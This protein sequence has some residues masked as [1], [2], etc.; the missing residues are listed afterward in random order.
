MIAKLLLLLRCDA[1]GF[2]EHIT[3]SDKNYQK[4]LVSSI[5]KTG[6]R[7]YGEKEKM[8]A[9]WADIPERAF[10]Q[11]VVWPRIVLE[12]R[13]KPGLRVL[14]IGARTYSWLPL[15]YFRK[16]NVSYW[17]LEP[18][19]PPY[20]FKP[21][22]SR[23]ENT[24]QRSRLGLAGSSHKDDD[25]SPMSLR[26]EHL[27]QATTEDF[28]E[29]DGIGGDRE[30]TLSKF[31]HFFDIVIDA[32]VL[33]G[34][35]LLRQPNITLHLRGV[36]KLMK[37]A[38]V[39]DMDPSLGQTEMPER[40]DTRLEWDSV[41]PDVNRSLGNSMNRGLRNA[42]DL[43]DKMVRLGGNFDQH[44]KL[45]VPA[46]ALRSGVEPVESVGEDNSF[47]PTN[48]RPLYLVKLEGGSGAGYWNKYSWK[49]L[50][51]K[52][53][54]SCSCESCVTSPDQLTLEEISD[55]SD[56]ALRWSPC[57]ARCCRPAELYYSQWRFLKQFLLEKYFLHT[58][59]L[60]L[61]ARGVIAHE[62]EAIFLSNI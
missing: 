61:E 34:Y 27:I 55:V 41:F 57:W 38:S 42:V 6:D 45:H 28:A 49:S 15:E 36:Q 30:N 2:S 59:G 24:R 50:R 47:W 13:R 1:R 40:I 53:D 31:I 35:I 20:Y 18:E 46:G 17:Q 25:P 37:R 48:G 9:Y 7:K 62:F 58:T 23:G 29:I 5:V 60:D 33:D 11:Y 8:W 54:Y 10:M 14:E 26:R 39:D 19:P 22:S 12:S 3:Y 21:P 44:P 43:S 51:W 32:G 16:H 4:D 56:S 52:H